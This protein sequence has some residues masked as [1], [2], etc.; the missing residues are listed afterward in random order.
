VSLKYGP[1]VAVACCI[2]HNFLIDS[3]EVGRD[4]ELD[5]NLIDNAKERSLL[6]PT[7]SEK[8]SESRA[9]IQ[10]NLLFE[11]WKKNQHI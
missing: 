11:E 4:D 9:K 8:K 10:R 3:R 1:V 5:D 6:M 2:L 7:M